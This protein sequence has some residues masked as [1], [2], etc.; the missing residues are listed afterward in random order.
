MRMQFPIFGIG[1]SLGWALLPGLVPAQTN[2]SWGRPISAAQVA[3]PSQGPAAARINPAE[4]AGVR[5]ASIAYGYS[6]SVSGKSGFDFLQLA[7][8]TS[9]LVDWPIG[10]AV[11][12][13]YM[14]RATASG[15][16][17][18]YEES[19]YAP[20]IAVSY[21]ADPRSSWRIAAGLT[22]SIGEYSVF[23]TFHSFANGISA[24]TAF[25]AEGRAGRFGLGLAYHDLN[26][27]EVRLPDQG[28]YK[29]RGWRE[30]SLD[31]SSSG[32]L[33][34]MRAGLFD[35]E[36]M[37]RAEGPNWEGGFGLNGW[38]L[39]LRPLSWFALKAER[40][41]LSSMSNLGVVFY[42]PPEILVCETRLE[43][44]LGHSGR[45]GS[46]LPSPF[47]QILLLDQER[48]DGL[49]WHVGLSLSAGI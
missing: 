1:L 34:R 31:W 18:S 15:S 10:F 4:L 27:P 8:G 20:G 44:N 32:R 24:G 3:L 21:P 41:F 13:G 23:D 42:P 39:E 30:Y 37:D 14:D 29:I 36:D 11:G 38:E 16:S 17:F 33:L 5:L 19:E 48:D 6:G 46:S 2:Y 25:S 43:L 22:L 12:F 35:E 49:G 9:G 47:R 28:F 7:A 40:T 26:S 45:G